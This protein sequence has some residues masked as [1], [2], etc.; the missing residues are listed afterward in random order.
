[1]KKEKHPVYRLA[2]LLM[3][4]ALALGIVMLVFSVLEGQGIWPVPG[5][6]SL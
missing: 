1:M 2:L 5:T 4:L 3:L 6:R